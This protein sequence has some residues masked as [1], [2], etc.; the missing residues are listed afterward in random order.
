M[1]ANHSEITRRYTHAQ[2]HCGVH[3]GRSRGHG[4]ARVGSLHLSLSW[5]LSTNIVVEK[6]PVHIFLLGG[7]HR[8]RSFLFSVYLVSSWVFSRNRASQKLSQF[9]KIRNRFCEP[10][11]LLCWSQDCFSFRTN[12]ENFDLKT[13]QISINL[14]YSLLPNYLFLWTRFVNLPLQS[15]STNVSPRQMFER[16]FSN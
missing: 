3:C 13:K 5:D 11:Y 16:L 4:S 15:L 7:F 9:L 1:K 2:G 10:G 6:Q 14:K 12:E 8:T